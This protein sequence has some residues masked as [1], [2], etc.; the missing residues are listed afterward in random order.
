MAKYKVHTKWV[1]Y[2]AVVVEASS[3]EEAEEKVF[4]GD[5]LGCD[6]EHTGFGLDYGYDNEE[7]VEVKELENE[8]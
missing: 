8:N 7:V 2:S 6:A 3:P 5:Y 4:S 1:G